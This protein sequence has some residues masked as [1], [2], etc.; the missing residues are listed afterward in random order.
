MV[1]TVFAEVAVNDLVVC[2]VQDLVETEDMDTDCIEN[3]IGNYEEDGDCNLLT[4]IKHQTDAFCA[5]WSFMRQRRVCSKIFSVGKPLFYW[6][7]HREVSDDEIKKREIYQNIKWNGHSVKDLLVYPHFDSIKT[8]AL[9][10]GLVTATKFQKRVVE[11]AQRYFELKKCRKMKSGFDDGAYHFEI[12][13]ESGLRA[14]HLH[15]LILYTDFTTFCTEFSQTFR[16]LSDNDT[17]EDVVARNSKYFFTAKALREVVTL[18]GSCGAYNSEYGPFYCGINCILNVPQFAVSFQCP[19]STTK[20]KEIALRF[21]GESGMMMVMDNTKGD[22]VYEMFLNVQWLSCYPE[23][24]ERLLIGSTRHLKVESVVLINSAKNYRL[25]FGAFAKLDQALNGVE[26]EEEVTA[27]ERDIIIGAMKSVKGTEMIQMNTVRSQALDQFAVDNFFL[28]TLQ[29]TKII[30]NLDWLDMM[31]SEWMKQL[32]VYSTSRR[33]HVKGAH[34]TTNVVKAELFQLFPNL[35]TVTI[36]DTYS[37]PFSLSRLLDELSAVELPA[38][39]STVS[40]LMGR[41]GWIQKE[42]N[43][44]LRQKAGAM[45]M[46]IVSG[47]EQDIILRLNQ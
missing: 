25:P 41:R 3:E 43:P 36:T 37:Y 39:L 19:T 20:T 27:K 9:Q 16:E 32:L 17:I 10:S 46:E 24:D 2:R 42:V 12:E 11:K 26:V 30:L 29:K 38:S 40:I 47:W 21:A 35:S 4:A 18:F 44:A 22:A 14:E 6:K 23:E 15:A 5:M 34:D 31:E 28:M 8:E 13:Y 7:W 33:Q 1:S 45:N